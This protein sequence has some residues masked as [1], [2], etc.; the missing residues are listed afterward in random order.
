MYA[1]GSEG[2]P[3]GVVP[4]E[5]CTGTLAWCANHYKALNY[6]DKLD[7]FAVRGIELAP[8]AEAFMAVAQWATTDAGASVTVNA[9]LQRLVELF[10]G[11]GASR[12]ALAAAAND[13][14]SLLINLELEARK[15]T[16]VRAAVDAAMGRLRETSP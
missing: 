8:T 14:Q 2:C 3:R 11:A 4:D 16:M 7:C 13:V 10:R 9:M 12:G 15:G 5:R 6:S 1:T